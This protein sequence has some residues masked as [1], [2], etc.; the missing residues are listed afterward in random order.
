VIGRHEAGPCVAD[1][2]GV[3]SVL[4]KAQSWKQEEKVVEN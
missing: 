2:T 4:N 1:R 3:C